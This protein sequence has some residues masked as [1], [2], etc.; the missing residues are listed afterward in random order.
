[1]I[2]PAGRPVPRPRIEWRD[3][4]G[5]LL[6]DKQTGLSSNAALQGVRRLYRARKAGHTGSLDPLASGLLPVCFGQATKASGMLLDAEKTYL[7]TAELGVRTATG[8]AEGGVVETRPVPAVGEHALDAVLSDFL[9]QIE[10]VPP[11]YSALRHE[12]RRLYELARQGV[13]VPREPRT[14][15]I[16]ELRRTGWDGRLLSFEVRCSKGTYVRTLVEDIATALGTVGHVTALRRTRLGPFR[17]ERM[18]TLQELEALAT[19][20]GESALDEVLH[21]P[22]RALRDWPAVTLGVAEQAY[23]LQG[24]A[25]FVAAPAGARVRL[26]GPGGVFLGVGQA[27]PEGRRVSPVRIMVDLGPGQPASGSA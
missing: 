20:G 1:M 6:L 2:A 12:G 19:R 11:M 7:V 18:W 9:G 15:H 26:Y 4:D 25:V 14:I 27:T 3:V 13:E 16:H 24:Q 21:P 22:D 5:I 8:D 23:V 17:D 10:Q